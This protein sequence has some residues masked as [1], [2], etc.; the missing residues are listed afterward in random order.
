[1]P[2]GLRNSALRP[3]AH[4]KTLPIKRTLLLVKHA[5]RFRN[6]PKTLPDVKLVSNKDV[7]LG[8]FLNNMRTYSFFHR[9]AALGLSFTPVNV[10]TNFNYGTALAPSD[11]IFFFN[12]LN[13]LKSLTPANTLLFFYR[14]TNYSTQVR[15]VF[16]SS[17][18][19][20]VSSIYSI[21]SKTKL[22]LYGSGVAAFSTF[23]S[24]YVALDYTVF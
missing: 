21:F 10:R 13:S 5:L 4:Y 19:S 11:S 1:M 7:S 17:I 14:V 12:K 16:F 23:S 22:N 3:T 8:F 20:F 2:T 9:F 15:P 6:A 18:L 24:T